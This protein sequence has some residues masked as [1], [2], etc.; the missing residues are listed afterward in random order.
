MKNLVLFLVFPFSLLLIS[1]Y[2]KIKISLAKHIHFHTE[3]LMFPNSFHNEV[4]HG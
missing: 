2:S 4:K 1:T 3:P